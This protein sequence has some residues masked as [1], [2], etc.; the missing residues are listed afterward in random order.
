M[1]RGGMHD[2]VQVQRP[3]GSMFSE[4]PRADIE[5]SQFDRSHGLKTTFDCDLIVPI[6]CDEVLPGDTF[7]CRM[8]GFARVFS[9]LK[10]PI[11]DN[12]HMDFHF[13]FVPYRL[14]WTNWEHFNGALDDP[15]DLGTDYTIPILDDGFT[16][17]EDSLGD[18]FGLPLGLQSTDVEV[19]SL[20][21]RA[22]Y[23]IYNE[24]YRDQNLIDT[25]VWANGDGPD[26]IGLYSGDPLKRA[27][28]HDYFTS[29]LPWPQ[30][31]DAVDLPLGTKAPVYGIGKENQ[32]YVTSPQNVYEAGKSVLSTYTDAQEIDP[33]TAGESVWIEEDPGNAGYPNIFAD[34]TAATA[35]TINQ[36][37]EAF[38][39]QRLLERD[40]R[41]GTRYVEIIKSHFGVTSPD[42]RLQRPEYLG[43]GKSFINVAPV[44][45]TSETAATPQGVLTAVGTGA[46]NG[47]GWAKSFTEHGV[48]LGLASAYSDLTYQQGLARMFSRQTR[49]DFYWPALSRIGEQ[50]VL[51]K[52][53]FIAN[54]AADEEVFGY[55]ERYAEYR[56]APSRITGK[57][58]SDAGGSLDLWHLSQDFAASPA[59]NQTFIQYDTPMARIQ[60][61]TTEPDIIL[62]AWFELKCARPMPLFGVPGM[63]DHF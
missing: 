61:V 58:R 54:G 35:A 53:L 1:A 21:G 6:F 16:V 41:G 17:D 57:F 37:R 56:Y 14:L 39:I 28:R 10:A 5:R 59:L 30:K 12:L 7:T 33:G 29:C 42:F 45:Q 36:L 15:G 20:P 23:F 24:W 49:Y 43:G 44:A 2:M 9:P 8:N 27:K 11:M 18:Y 63:I 62:D 34:L 40:A 32:V 46:L 55:Q 22:Y 25:V 3:A 13:F 51:K 38:Q 50:A 60:A 19:S 4:V 26:N 48:V 31:G 52:E 47:I